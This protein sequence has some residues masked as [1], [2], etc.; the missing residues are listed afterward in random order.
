M[1]QCW[2]I[3]GT[4]KSL[5]NVLLDSASTITLIKRSIIRHNGLAGKNVQ[6]DV[7]LACGGS[8]KSFEQEVSIQLASLDGRYLSP[9]FHAITSVITTS[10]VLPVRLKLDTYKDVKNTR[11]TYSYPQNRPTSVDLL[12]DE[13]MFTELLL[14]E[15]VR[16]DFNEPRVLPTKLGPVLAGAYPTN[17]PQ[18][19][20]AHHV[21]KRQGKVCA[22]IPDYMAFMSLEDIGI[23]E[24]QDTLLSAEDEEAE[25]MMKELTSYDPQAKRYTTGLLWKED[26]KVALDSNFAPAKYITISAKKKSIKDGKEAQVNLAYLEQIEAGF[27]EEVPREEVFPAHATYCIPTHPVYKPGSL[28]TKTRIVFNASHKCKTTGKSLNDV[29]YQG[30]TLLPDLVKI[31]LKFRL[32]KHVVVAD[33]S[34]MFWKVAMRKQDCDCLRYLW[35]FEADGPIRMYRALSVTF[36]VISAPYQAVWVVKHHSEKFQSEFPLAAEVIKDTLYMDDVTALYDDEDKAI[37]AT[38]QIFDLFQ[39]A[40][41]QPHKWNSSSDDILTK[42]EIPNT[43]WANVDKQ[44]ILGVQWET[45]DDTIRFDFSEVLSPVQK[46]TKRSLISEASRLFDPLGL[47]APFTLKAKLL[48]QQCWVKGIDWDEKLPTDIEDEWL[49]WR[50]EIAQLTEIEQPRLVKQTTS[51]VWLAVFADASK[52]AYAMCAYIVQDSNATSKLLFSKTRVAPMKN[53]AVPDE[54]V[55][56]A[57]LELLASLI[58][59]RVVKYLLSALGT[60]YFTKIRYFTDS[61]IT[62]HR[63]KN[64]SSKYKVWVANRLKEIRDNSSPETWYYIPG[65]LNPADVASRSIGAD[66]LLQN[67]LWWTGPSF[68]H[69]SEDFWPDHKALTKAEADEREQLEKMELKP[70]KTAACYALITRENNPFL[71]LVERVEKRGKL[72]RVT[73]FVL[74]FLICKIPSIKTKSVLIARLANLRLAYLTASNKPPLRRGK[75]KQKITLPIS[76]SEIKVAELFWIRQSQWTHYGPDVQSADPIKSLNATQGEDNIWRFKSRVNRED[77]IPPETAT[78]IILPKNCGIIERLVLSVHVAYAHAGPSYT[79]HYL[80]Q[81]YRLIGGKR[82]LNRILHKCI[83]VKCRKVSRMQQDEASFPPERLKMALPWQFIAI[84]FFGPLK[85]K[86]EC[87]LVNCPHPKTE[88]TYG[89]LFTCFVTRAIHIE[90]CEDLSTEN[91]LFAFTRLISRRGLPTMVWSDNATTFKAADKELCRLY[92]AVNWLKIQEHCTTKGIYWQ[93]GTAHA[94]W[95]NGIVERLVRTVKDALSGIISNSLLRIRHLESVL[96]ECEGIV[97]NRPISSPPENEL[98]PETVTPAQLCLGRGLEPL[99]TEQDT[100]IEPFTKLHAYRKH[101]V[102]LF[103]KRWSKD[104]LMSLQVLKGVKGN[105]PQIEVGQVVLVNEKNLGKNV[106]QMARVQGVSH[107]RDGKIRKVSLIVKKGG[108]DRTLERHINTLAYL[109]SHFPTNLTNLKPKAT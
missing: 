71:D 50:R 28:T 11:F 34:K 1:I 82:E 53:V 4:S 107:G 31:L 15:R 42:A 35:Q 76:A 33:I 90:L 93:F 27:A 5:I 10:P 51:P 40:S 109:E 77:I 60:D 63:I 17:N 74:R 26:P 66:D 12:L 67:T 9:P 13:N 69:K 72:C 104:Y 14:D 43:L 91:F 36:G 61:L 75:R 95:T 89:C 78:P 88:K 81:R 16:G 2:L 41:M 83:H 54:Y 23:K 38:K 94:P 108:K 32:F 19:E 92:N 97:N 65:N 45:K 105:S 29:L 22:T 96:I 85:T 64:G 21:H 79:M 20:Q 18:A 49:V 8:K 87:Q 99:P 7:S 56:I 73:A 80:R 100:T 6:L 55:T 68:I 44:S 3:C 86:H 103:W 25:R 59:T 58:A 98:D 62:Y 101:L 30:P 48:F 84:D 106:W 52:Y 37:D 47:I 46:H 24:K 102:Q 70:Q 57:R 39:L